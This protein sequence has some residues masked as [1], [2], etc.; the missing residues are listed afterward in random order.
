MTDEAGVVRGDTDSRDYGQERQE[1]SMVR[2]SLRTLATA[3]IVVALASCASGGPPA[4]GFENA[5]E[6]CVPEAGTSDVRIEGDQLRINNKGD[7]D[8]SG[9]PLDDVWCLLAELEV[10][11]DIVDSMV[12]TSA[13]DGDQTA[14]FGGYTVTWRYHPNTGLDVF[15]D[16]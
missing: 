16:R 11:E 10:P 8:N 5:M 13:N 3:S 14:E 12:Q 9:I 6:A 2:S 7:Q 1:D 4:D 15:I